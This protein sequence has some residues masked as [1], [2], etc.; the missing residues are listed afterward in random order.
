M[1]RLKIGLVGTS[2][3]SFPGDKTAVFEKSIRDLEKLAEELAFDLVPYTEN[4]IVEEDARRAAAFFEEQKINFLLIQNTSYSA[5]FL[6]LVFA[7]MKNVRLGL[8]AIREG[9][10]DGVVPFNSLCSINMHQSIIYH[11]LKADRVK[12]KWFYGGADEAPFIRRLKVTVR[13]LQA[14]KNLQSSRVA[15]VGGIAPGFNDLYNDERQFLHLFDG[16]SYNRLHEYDE[17]K[18]M[19]MAVP[20]K[21]AEKAAR[22]IASCACGADGHAKEHLLLSARFYLAY[23]RFIE[24]NRYDAVAVSCWPKF[25]NDFRYSVCSVVA[26]LNDDGIPVGCEGDILSTVCMLALKY[27]AGDNTALMDL[28]AFD[29]TDETVLMWHCGPASSRFGKKYQ[30]GANYTGMPHVKGE[31]PVGCGVVRDMVFDEMPVTV[32]RLTGE[33]DKYM[34]MSGRFIGSEKKSFTGSRGWLGDVRMNGES[35]GVLDLVNTV[36]VNGFQHHYPMVPGCLESEIKEF[37]AWL[38]LRPLEKVPYADH[39]QIID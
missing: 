35:I 27:I 5:G 25:Q 2:Q 39:L 23:K 16:M 10:S 28:S 17:L 26:Q 34:L 36:Q 31:P 30:L 18:A 15:L 4:V 7:K 24:E 6:S 1:R 32:F 12:V 13:A 11:Y 9:A 20:E 33:C 8:W 37:A 38:G 21:E 3:L 22:Q 19:A 14:I 29:D